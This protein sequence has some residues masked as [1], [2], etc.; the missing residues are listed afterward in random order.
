MQN[1]LAVVE[2]LFFTVK[3]V[4]AAKRAGMQ[5]TFVKTEADVFEKC[6]TG[7][8][9]VIIDLNLAS[10]EPI[11]LIERLKANPE[12][13]RISLLGYVSHVQGELK[14]KAHDAGCDAVLAKSAFST[15]IQQI[16]RR[17]SG[18]VA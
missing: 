15:N 11:P 2:D 5:V 1:I 4:D 17:H 9:L 10:I 8:A 3:I 16:L 6:K 13:A 14:Q 7:I 12:T 18:K